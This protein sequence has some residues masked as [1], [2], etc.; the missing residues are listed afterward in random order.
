MLV[1]LLLAQCMAVLAAFV[2]QA[3]IVA[4]H[5]ARAMRAHTAPWHRLRRD[6]GAMSTPPT[7]ANR[8]RILG[9]VNAMGPGALVLA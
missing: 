8:L 3:L 9:Q 7:T 1:N 6:L 2:A 5:E 4:T